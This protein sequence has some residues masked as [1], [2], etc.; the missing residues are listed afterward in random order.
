MSI[1][2]L[3]QLSVPIVYPLRG[4]RTRNKACVATLAGFLPDSDGPRHEK[5]N[6]QAAKT[7]LVLLGIA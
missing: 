5:V 4:G 2:S 7:F 1:T 6:H 3:E